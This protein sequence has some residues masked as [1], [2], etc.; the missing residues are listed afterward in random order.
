MMSLCEDPGQRLFNYIDDNA[1]I[2]QLLAPLIVD[3]HGVGTAAIAHSFVNL[4]VMQLATA[5]KLGSAG[6]SVANWPKVRPHNSKGAEF[7][8]QRPNFM[9]TLAVKRVGNTG[10]GAKN[11]CRQFFLKAYFKGKQ[12]NALVSI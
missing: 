1:L 6:G 12:T 7:F 8:S 11:K 5:D 9:A 3:G 10:R 4:S 2:I